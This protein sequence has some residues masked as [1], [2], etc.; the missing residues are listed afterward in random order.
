LSG[1]PAGTSAV[2]VNATVTEASGDGYLTVHPCTVVAPLASTLNFVAGQTV[3]N[4]ATVGSADGAL[5]LTASAPTHAIVDI[6]AL[7]GAT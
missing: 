5:C 3:A 4:A 2:T 7:V 6:T 1:L